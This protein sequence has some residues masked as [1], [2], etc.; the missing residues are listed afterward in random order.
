M[1]CVPALFLVLLEVI[2]S[3][4]GLDAIGLLNGYRERDLVRVD[5]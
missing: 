3:V 1:D 5:V 2:D 4:V